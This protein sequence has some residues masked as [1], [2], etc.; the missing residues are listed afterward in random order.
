MAKRIEWTPLARADVRRI[1]RHTALGLL[2][3]LADYALNGYGDVDRL[4]DVH[5]PESRL[6]VREYR[7]RFYD[8][9]N[10]IEILR[11]VHR[12]EA[13]ASHLRQGWIAWRSQLRCGTE[14]VG[15]FGDE[16][17]ESSNAAIRTLLPFAQLPEI[18][19]HRIHITRR[20]PIRRSAPHLI[21]TRLLSLFA[22]LQFER[23]EIRQHLAI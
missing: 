7:I 15:R 11:V 23:F 12:R 21:A 16:S 4:T 13:Y 9:G 18:L 14:T 8:H 22:K 3:D 6:R 19:R 17:R 10:W 1:D 5:P 2:E 20:D